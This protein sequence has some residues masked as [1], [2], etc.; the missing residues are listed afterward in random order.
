MLDSWGISVTGKT[1]QAFFAEEKEKLKCLVQPRQ[2]LEGLALKSFVDFN[3]RT[4]VSRGA[5]RI[6]WTGL[7]N[8]PPESKHLKAHTNRPFKLFT[9]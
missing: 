9:N 6:S 4:E 1:P 3:V 7:A 8:A 5:R 2:A